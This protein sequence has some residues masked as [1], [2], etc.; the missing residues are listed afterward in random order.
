MDIHMDWNDR[1]DIVSIPTKSIPV[2]PSSFGFES[3]GGMEIGTGM[4]MNFDRDGMLIIT[5]WVSSL[6]SLAK[7]AG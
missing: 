4:E 1:G 5:E 3:L 6:P 7:F 2:P